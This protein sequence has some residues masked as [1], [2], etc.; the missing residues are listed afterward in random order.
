MTLRIRKPIKTTKLKKFK[1]EMKWPLLNLCDDPLWM[2][3]R[4]LWGLHSTHIDRHHVLTILPNPS[5]IEIW[6][7]FIKEKKK[8]DFN[9]QMTF[10]QSC[11]H[12]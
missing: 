12:D 2:V 4:K 5:D 7:R 3:Q 8:K 9:V 10:K 1:L 6:Y 11:F